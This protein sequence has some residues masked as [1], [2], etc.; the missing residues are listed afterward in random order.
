MNIVFTFVYAVFC[1]GNHPLG[2]LKGEEFL[3]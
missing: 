2:F 1:N 3:D